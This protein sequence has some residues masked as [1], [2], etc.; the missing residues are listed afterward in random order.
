MAREPV[1][2][3]GAARRARAKAGALRARNLQLLQLSAAPENS[4]R[5]F[6]GPGA[7]ASNASGP[8]WTV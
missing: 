3:G 1:K 6:C 5:S 7:G 4:Q 8:I 2:I